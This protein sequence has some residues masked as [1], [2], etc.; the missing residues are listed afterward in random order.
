MTDGN[1]KPNKSAGK[2]SSKAV[3]TF[4]KNTLED[5]LRIPQAIEQQNA[6]NPMRTDMLIKAV[7]FN[8]TSD[9]RFLDLL[10]SSNL[11]GLVEGSGRQANVSITPIGNDVIAPG[12]PAQRQAALLSAFR[13][14]EDFK[15]VEDF[16]KCKKL[17]E[18]EF[19]E[20]TLVREFHIPRERVQAF[21][22]IF[23]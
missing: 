9:W 2:A 12:S 14:V 5:A 3:W 20:N 16:Y 13:Q 21:I 22:Q 17:P 10:K 8:S 23:T 15:K 1:Q 4:P 6:G 19:F 11:Y 18:D 7:G